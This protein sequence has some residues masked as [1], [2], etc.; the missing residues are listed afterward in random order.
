MGLTPCKKLTISVIII[1][2]T[3]LDKNRGDKTVIKKAIIVL[4]VLSGAALLAL[5]YHGTTHAD[6][7]GMVWHDEFTGSAVSGEWDILKQNTD[8]LRNTHL[9]YSPNNLK[10][11]N[12]HLEITTQRHCVSNLSEPLTSANMS[13]QPCPS[14]TTTRYLSGRVKNKGKVVDGTKPFRAEIRAKF[15]WNGKRGTRPSLWMVSGNTLQNCNDNPKA[16]D[17]YGELDIIEWYSSTPNYAWSTTHMSCYHHGVDA[18]WKTGWRTRAL[19]HSGEHYAGARPGSFAYEWHTWAVEYDGTT[20]KYFVDDQPIKVYRYHVSPTDDGNILPRTDTE[21]LT[22]VASQENI[23]GAFHRGWQFILNDYV[24]ISKNLSPIDP[25]EPFPTQTMLIDYVR[26]FQK[27]A[28]TQPP[29]T[30]VPATGTKWT[31]QNAAG[32]RKWSALT[33]SADGNKLAAAAWGGTIHTSQDGG[34]TWTEQPKSEVRNW[35]SIA[36]SADGSKIAALY[37]WG[38]YIMTSQDGG[39][40]WHKHAMSG[41]INWMSIASSADGNKLVAVAKDH[42]IYTSRDGG[43]TWMEQPKSGS[44]KWRAV[45]SSADGN[46]LAAVVE[47]GA[48]YTSSNGGATWTE[49][50]QAG[51]RTW[52]SIASSPDGTKLVATAAG[53]YIYT[54]TDGGATWTERSVDG[55]HNWTAATISADGSTLAA[56]AGG[57]GY[58]Y[59]ST[60][61][62]ATWTAQTS[63]STPNWSALAS[64]ADGSK[65][66]AAA[67]GGMVYTTTQQIEDGTLAA[68][69]AAVAQAEASKSP[70][71][72][73]AAQARIAAVKDARKKAALQARLNAITSAPS[74]TTP[75]QPTQ[76][77]NSTTIPQPHGGAV[78]L[79]TAGKPCSHIA[80]AEPATAPAQ[81]QGRVLR[82]SV[83]FT[84]TCAG[85]TAHTGYTTH[86]ALTLSTR[87]RDPSRLTVLKLAKGGSVIEDIT[88]RINFGTNPSGT[89]TTIAYD[90]T[91]GGF[92]DEDGTANG[93]ILDPIAIYEDTSH[94]GSTSN[95][96]RP[97]G[98]LA[99]T[100]DSLLPTALAAIALGS[101][102]VWMLRRRRS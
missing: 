86:V 60:D 29:E 36:S 66:A 72:I 3:F 96:S 85:Q 21:P 102:G 77:T 16:N 78:S 22:K 71:D 75:N 101:G 84:I 23:N 6:Q 5:L 11:A 45:T 82:N 65:L 88:N 46:K 93:T 25:S 100:G 1:A 80:S 55:R 95:S 28:G 42:V 62:G 59:V 7:W 2:I 27:G 12:S 41:S 99:N 38:G 67:Y 97:S 92:G 51:S 14:G 70:A 26:V 56:T 98:L 83:R 49:R 89:R 47:D 87:Y 68:A 40:T 73:A 18:K 74:I 35:V 33:S 90:V 9:A 79:A 15:N 43:A 19:S 64:S 53:G 58:I 39:A 32:D 44:R 54:S 48:I 17:P 8:N 20:V 91:D 50:T 31:K 57:G 37:D 61:G 94:T 10:V 34:A 76:P 69:E 24:E 13:E 52:T 81:Y 63:A 30:P 4:V